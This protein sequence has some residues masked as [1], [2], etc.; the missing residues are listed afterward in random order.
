MEDL[1]W[2]DDILWPHLRGMGGEPNNHQGVDNCDTLMIH[3]CSLD[4]KLWYVSRG[5]M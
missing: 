1:V 5:K 2:M 3:G 4:K